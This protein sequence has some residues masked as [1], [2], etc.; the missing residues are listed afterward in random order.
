[1][2]SETMQKEGTGKGVVWKYV[3]VSVCSTRLKVAMPW[4][5]EEPRTSL[6]NAFFQKQM[7]LTP[8][9]QGKYKVN[10]DCLVMPGVWEWTE[11]TRNERMRGKVQG[12]SEGEI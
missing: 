9:R 12:C 8:W 1:M 5:P 11:M 7:P 3:C 6:L 4:D 10:L 2:A